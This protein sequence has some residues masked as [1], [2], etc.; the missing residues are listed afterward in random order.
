MNR[1]L[2]LPEVIEIV[3]LSR[4]TI[5]N[6]I[7]LEVFPKPMKLGPRAVGWLESDIARWLEARAE[8]EE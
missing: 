5:Y 1:V 2:R 3:S 6:L 7:N 4:S 8:L